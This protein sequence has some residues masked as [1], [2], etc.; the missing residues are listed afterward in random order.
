LGARDNRELV[1]ATYLAPCIQ[2]V[3]EFVATRVGE[4]LH[5]PTRLIVGDSFDQ[6]RE[7]EVDFAFLCGLPYVRLKREN[8]AAVEAIAA[9]IV[10]GDRYDDRPVYFSDV[11]VP[12]KSPAATF[13]D[14]RGRSWAYNE[15]DSHSGYLI[16]LWTLVEMDET[17]AFFDRWEM[18]RFHQE[19]VRLVAAAQVE[20]SAVDS[21]VLDVEM[22]DH[23]ELAERIRVIGTLGPSTIQPLVATAAVTAELRQE[24]TDIV[25]SLGTIENDR[26]SLSAGAVE[27]FVAIDDSAYGDIRS[28]LEAVEG[29]GF[30]HA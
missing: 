29:A 11:I 6:V 8:A 5:R 28:K 26:G 7:G 30:L 10:Q 9:P 17:P 14:L 25:V 23:P 13:G 2:P 19:S 18:T 4:E 15:P 3:Y 22:R 21:Q 24:V 12:A 27:R 1:F 16:T 20:G